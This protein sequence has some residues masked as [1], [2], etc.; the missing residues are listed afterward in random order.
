MSATNCGSPG[1]VSSTAG[2][3][4]VPVAASVVV[5]V[6]QAEAV[7]AMTRPMTHARSLEFDRCGLKVGSL[8]EV[9]KRAATMQRYPLNRQ[10][11][12]QL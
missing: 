1:P 4:S 3:G 12:A 11:L 9:Y 5:D 10:Q 2:A 6:P 8:F 7:S